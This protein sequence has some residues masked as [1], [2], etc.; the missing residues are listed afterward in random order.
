MPSHANIADFVL[1]LINEDFAAH[2][3]QTADLNL[4]VSAFKNYSSRD[5]ELGAPAETDSTSVLTA[6]LGGLGSSSIQ[7]A[8]ILVRF[9]VLC[10][11]DL[12]EVMRD[13]GILGV[14]LVMY[15]ML[16]VLIALMFLN[17]GDSFND[18]DVVARVSVLFFVA[19][20]MVFMSVAVLPFFVMQR[21]VFIR[22]RCNEAVRFFF[23]LRL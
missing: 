19:A 8:S 14:R 21:P 22:E 6:R 15:S 23:S 1:G 10:G 9:L 20:F 18:S 12:R 4:L 3:R 13:P 11:R 5:L 7:R 2:G 16:S 17:L